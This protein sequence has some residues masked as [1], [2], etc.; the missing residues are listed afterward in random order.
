MSGARPRPFAAIAVLTTLVGGV[1]ARAEE[2]AL[3]AYLADRGEGLPT[4]LFGTYV[5]Q[6]DFIFYPFYEYTKTTQ[7]EYK[8]SE[9]G[10]T[11]ETDFLGETVEQEYLVYFAY[12]FTKRLAVEL[13]VAAYSTTTFDKAK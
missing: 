7:F 10:F 11:G 4:S 12:G 2:P 9:L 5:G 1:G 3:P 8:P 6:G 13:E